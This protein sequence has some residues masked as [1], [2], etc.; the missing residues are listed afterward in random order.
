MEYTITNDN[1]LCVTLSKIEGAEN[2]FVAEIK[3]PKYQCG[4]DHEKQALTFIEPTGGPQIAVG[5]SLKEYGEGL[6]DEV[7]ES[8][9]DTGPLIIIKTSSVQDFN[10][11]ED[12]QD[13][14]EVEDSSAE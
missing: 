12:S 5:T 4:F 11:V 1:G 7:I 14:N 10:E 3:T 13:F 8:I 9:A 6:P 2:I